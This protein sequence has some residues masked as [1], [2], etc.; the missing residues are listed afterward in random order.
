MLADL[1]DPAAVDRLAEDGLA[2]LGG[3]D[4]LVNNAGI[5]KRRHTLALDAATVDSVMQVN[6]LGAHAPDPRA[7]APDGR[8]RWW[9]HRQR[10][11]GGGDAVVT[12]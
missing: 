11:L 5:P 9:P 4:V 12:R 2:A 6:F 8:T 10:L 3:V 7:A 1:G